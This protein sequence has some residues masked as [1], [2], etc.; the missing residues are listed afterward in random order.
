[1]GKVGK[2]DC[3]SLEP[4]DPHAWAPFEVF[5]VGIAASMK[6][7]D[8]SKETHQLN[9]RLTP[10]L[11]HRIKLCKARELSKLHNEADEGVEG[12][13]LRKRTERFQARKR[14]FQANGHD[15]DFL[16]HKRDR[17]GSQTIV[18]ILAAAARFCRTPGN[19]SALTC[20]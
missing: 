15:T 17:Q 18:P 14:R 3:L 6:L 20:L 7:S 9:K 2:H 19:T 4:C 8:S 16:Q 11:V 5:S 12:C 10:Y 1:M 13:P